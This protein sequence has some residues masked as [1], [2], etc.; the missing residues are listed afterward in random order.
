M[1][2]REDNPL[3]LLQYIHERVHKLENKISTLEVDLQWI[4]EAVSKCEKQLSN[5]EKA[6]KQILFL[7]I[8]S[9]LIPLLR[10]LL[11]FSK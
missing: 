11:L 6:D 8:V 7:I 3:T 4:K 9:I 1:A 2:E 10:F 5:L